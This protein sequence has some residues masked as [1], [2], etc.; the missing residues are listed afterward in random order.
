MFRILGIEPHATAPTYEA[1]LQAVH[2]ED[3]QTVK[4]IIDSTREGQSFETEHRILH[5]DGTVRVVHTKGEV[6]CVDECQPRL[7]G[8]VQEVAS[9]TTRKVLGV[10]QDITERRE[11]EHRLEQLANTDSLTG[12]ATRRYFM[13]LAEKEVTRVHRYGGHLSL[14]MLDLDRFKDVN[15]RHGHLVGDRTLVKLA[16][17]FRSALRDVDLVGRLGGEEFAALLTETAHAE[18]MDVAL[19]L[20]QSIARAE[21]PLQPASPPLHFTASIGVATLSPRDAGIDALLERADK[22]L[23][24]AKN[25]GR[26]KVCTADGD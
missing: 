3:R 16:Q 7:F 19:R 25:T 18:A 22:A 12:C 26:N 13:A 20:H 24:Q 21:V 8:T 17:V 2:P 5:P 6:I 11:L 1:Y 14:L 4:A 15:D 23:Y 10:I 9:P